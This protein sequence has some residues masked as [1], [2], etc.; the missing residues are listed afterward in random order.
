MI[1]SP[2]SPDS[3]VNTVISAHCPYKCTG[4]IPATCS[5]TDAVSSKSRVASADKLNVRASISAKSGLAPQRRIELTVAKK[6]NGVVITESPGPIFNAASESH[7]ASVP[8]AQPIANGTPQAAAAASSNRPTSGP[9]IK[10]WDSHTEAMAARTS[11]RISANSRLKSS[12]G[13]ASSF[14][15]LF[16]SIISTIVI[17]PKVLGSVSVPRPCREASKAIG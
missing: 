6:L 13:T 7:R 17:V 10:R 9:S 12:M 16:I 1:L 5:S 4:M 8:L 3:A 2:R 11:S 15:L 14:G